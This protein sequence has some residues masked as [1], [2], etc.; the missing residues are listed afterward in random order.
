MRRVSVEVESGTPCPALGDAKLVRRAIEYFISNA[1][2]YTPPDTTISVT[3]EN[4]LDW[5]SVNV[6]DRG[7][8]V[9]AAFRETVFRKFGVVDEK[10]RSVRRG[11]GL[12]LHLATLVASSHGGKVSVDDNPGGGA[13]F[14]LYLPAKQNRA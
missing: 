13:V 1:L 10:S 9:P 14:R 5:V 3:F 12:G 4:G 2:R 6:A 7:P 11:Y 8:G